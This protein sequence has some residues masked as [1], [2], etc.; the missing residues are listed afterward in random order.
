MFERTLH[1]DRDDE[2]VDTTFRKLAKLHLDN[3]DH[4]AAAA[5]LRTLVDRL[6]AERKIVEAWRSIAQTLSAI[7]NLPKEDTPLVSVGR[8]YINNLIRGGQRGYCSL[9]FCYR[10]DYLL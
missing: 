7:S 2:K 1:H 8:H 3:D 5:T 9:R 4:M 10:E 6:T